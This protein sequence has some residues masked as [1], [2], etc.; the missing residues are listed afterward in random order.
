MK[1]IPK[2]S[3]EQWAA[4]Y[5]VV[6]EGSFA[7]AAE[8]MN[9][10]QSTVSYAVNKLNQMLPSPAL[11]LKGRKAELTPLGEVLFRQATQLLEQAHAI[12][13]AAKQ[14]SQGWESEIV[15]TVDVLTPMANIFAAL[16][17][18][19]KQCAMTR[20]KILETSLSGTDESL[21][22]RDCNIAITP[23]VPPGFLGTPISSTEMIPVASKNH[24]LAQLKGISENQLRQHR[25]VVVRDSGVK[26]EQ[27]AGWLGAEQRWTVDH[28][29]SSVEALE[30][31]LAFA[32]VPVH[33][34][35]QQ[36]ASGTLVKLALNPDAVRI[37]PLYMVITRPE[38]AGPAAQ[39]LAQ[40]LIEMFKSK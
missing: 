1:I 32:F 20:I 8:A 37:I 17:M 40:C 15:L 30:A 6:N 27:D 25:Q 24:P 2:I 33:K 38:T 18:F 9:K 7:K 31:G 21:F 11:I 22:N 29:A 39:S 13:E 3:L 5:T 4:F 16:E 36:L 12:E 28:F 26:R 10:S 23:R 14:L 35:T 19:T 34:I